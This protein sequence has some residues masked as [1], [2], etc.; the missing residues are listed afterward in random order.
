M[1]VSSSDLDLKAASRIM[2]ALGHENRLSLYR[3][4]AAKTQWSTSAESVICDI[5]A[6]LRIGAPTV[7]HHVKELERAGLIITQRQGKLLTARINPSVH[8]W[9]QAFFNPSEPLPNTDGGGSRLSNPSP[10]G[11]SST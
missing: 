7:S 6:S 9:V 10:S 5:A 1:P 8:Q 4:I 11:D 2:R 3:E